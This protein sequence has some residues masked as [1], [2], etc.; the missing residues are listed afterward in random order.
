MN[1]TEAIRAVIDATGAEPVVF[2]TGFSC[3]IARGIADRASHFYMTGSMGLAADIGIGIALHSTVP[4]VV[5][6]GDGSLAMNPGCLLTA[7][8]LPGLPLLHLLL[9][10]RSYESTGG[11]HVPSER[12]DF[13]ALAR[14]AGYAEVLCADGIGDFREALASGLTCSAPVFVHAVLAAPEGA[15]PPPRI[16]L[17]LDEVRR[18]FSDHLGLVVR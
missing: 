3:R 14:A 15:L 1:K 6:D 11:Q 9:D 4:V 7:G 12:V 8:A 5:V 2:T 18:R 13:C 16:D 10:D 17:G